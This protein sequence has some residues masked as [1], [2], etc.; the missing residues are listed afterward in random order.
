MPERELEG[1]ERR[2]PVRRRGHASPE[3]LETLVILVEVDGERD[4][5]GGRCLETRDRQRRPVAPLSAEGEVTQSSEATQGIG[6]VRVIGTEGTIISPVNHTP[7]A[8][9]A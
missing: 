7:S 6:C 1:L 2:D 8:G 9:G 4:E 5:L 3:R